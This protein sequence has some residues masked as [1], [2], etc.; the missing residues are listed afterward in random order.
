MVPPP[1][2]PHRQRM[3]RVQAEKPH[4][5]P[6]PTTDIRPHI[7]LQELV[8]SRHRRQS[9]CPYPRH[10][11]R[12]HSQPRRSFQGLQFQPRRNQG[13]YRLRRHRPMQ[14]G[15]MLPA[16]EQPPRPL[17][18]R[19]GPPRR[20][21]HLHGRQATIP[22]PSPQAPDEQRSAR[23]RNRNRNRKFDLTPTPT[24]TPAP[25]P[26]TITITITITIRMCTW[27]RDTS[28]AGHTGHP[29]L[30]SRPFR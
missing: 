19:P 12:H 30:R 10:P 21:M 20:G 18:N 14:K 27:G 15:Q 1:G 7:Q 9:P 2:H 16:H 25:A 3:I 22:T 29:S 13:S 11:K 23:S 5:R 26:A 28:A 17:R 8:R 24:P 4:P 6:S